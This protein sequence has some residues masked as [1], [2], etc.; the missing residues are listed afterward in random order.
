VVI[1]QFGA[2]SK[3]YSVKLWE[4]FV[5]LAPQYESTSVNFVMVNMDKAENKGLGTYLMGII[6]TVRVFHKGLLKRDFFVIEKL[7]TP[8]SDAEAMKELKLFTDKMIK[9]YPPAPKKAAF[10]PMM[11]AEAEQ[12]NTLVE[13]KSMEEFN[14]AIANNSVP[15]LVQFSAYW[16]GP[17]QRLK[18]KLVKIAPEYSMDKIRLYYVDAYVLADLKKYLQG[19]YPTSRVF[20][21]GETTKSSFVGDKSEA[22]VR[23]FLDQV[24]KEESFN[25]IE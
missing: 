9:Q 21:N 16:C 10:A 2:P 12:G 14:E 25:A 22:E 3:E 23:R 6:P 13:L 5:K 15:V 7:P 17:C 19:G 20:V 11:E 18:E 4:K 8:I 24:V 1:V